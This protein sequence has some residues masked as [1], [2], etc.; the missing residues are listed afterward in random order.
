VGD[1]GD[2]RVSCDS[3]WCT[4]SHPPHPDRPSRV[5]GGADRAPDRLS[6]QRSERR[7]TT[8]NRRGYRTFAA[9]S[10]VAEGP[11]IRAAPP[12]NWRKA[13]P[14]SRQASLPLR[15]SHDSQEL[16]EETA[17]TTKQEQSREP[18]SPRWWN[19]SMRGAESRCVN[20]STSDNA[21]LEILEIKS[22]QISGVNDVK[23][24]RSETSVPGDMFPLSTT[25]TTSS[26]SWI[27]RPAAVFRSPA[28]H[29]W[30][31]RL[32]VNDSNPLRRHVVDTKGGLNRGYLQLR[33]TASGKGPKRPGSRSITASPDGSCLR[34]PACG[35]PRPRETPRSR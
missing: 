25:S 21:R 18:Q 30:P 16:S 26:S 31:R 13:T 5:L 1:S 33:I 12:R 22:P 14:A 2:T 24:S 34:S 7:A 28:P 3:I 32:H 35:P 15:A 6:L 8:R 20:A 17:A 19:S 23:E 4:W 27:A 10:S 29:S 9:F 11:F